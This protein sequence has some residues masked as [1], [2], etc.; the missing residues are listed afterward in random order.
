MDFYKPN[1]FCKDIMVDAITF[2]SF[3]HYLKHDEINSNKKGNDS[4]H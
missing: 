1:F 4:T 2:I 3:I